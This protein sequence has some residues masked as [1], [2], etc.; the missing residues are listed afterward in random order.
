MKITFAGGV[1]CAVALLG[2]PSVFAQ[3][4]VT[5][6]GIVDAGVM[7]TNNLGGGGS[8]QLSPGRLGGDRFGL[9]GSEDLGSGLNAIFTLENGYN[10]VNG[11]IGQ[12]G[13]MFGRQAFVGLRS[14]QYGTVTLGRQYDALIDMV[15]LYSASGFWVPATHIGDNDNLDGSFRLNNSIKYR[16]PTFYGFSA[17]GV[18]AMSN[19]ASSAAGGFGNNRAWS[20]AGNYT[21]GPFSV[22]AGFQLLNHPNVSTNTSG[23]VGGASTTNG[24]DFSTIYFD[25]MDGGVARQQI[26]SAGG[27]YTFG[28]AT[29]TI[30]YSNVHID[31]NDGAYRHLSNYEA[32][33]RYRLRPDVLLIG[34]YVF[35]DGRAGA[36]PGTNGAVRDPKW[37]QVTLGVDYTLSKS[38]D[39]YALGSYQLAAGDPS[40]L[41]GGT[42]KSIAATSIA[43]A[44]ATNHQVVLMTGI[45]HRF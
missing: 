27:S 22:G 13:R 36:L 40:T 38:T 2:S 20:V 16:L 11:S 34:D 45:R 29:A 4:A 12:A 42:Y 15:S 21:Q 23:A 44:S 6:Y 43:G 24:D 32:S 5:L 41:V 35:T 17:E 14:N 25:G 7:Y 18:Y 39:I 3:S 1:A 31:Y 19:Q 37:H 26:A 30:N 33:L 10:G 9:R 8:V 28:Q